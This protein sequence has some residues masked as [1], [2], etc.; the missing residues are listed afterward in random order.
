MTTA[1]I[2]FSLS[3]TLAMFLEYLSASC[4]GWDSDTTENFLFVEKVKWLL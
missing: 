3:M 2:F 1:L 4:L